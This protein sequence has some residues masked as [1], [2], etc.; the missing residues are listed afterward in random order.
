MLAIKVSNK[1]AGESEG[2]YHQSKAILAII[3]FLFLFEEL[4]AKDFR[5]WAGTVLT[6]RTLQELSFFDSRAQAKRNVLRAI[7]TVAKRLGNAKAVCRKCYIHHDVLN[8]YSLT[9][10]LSRSAGREF[11]SK[12]HEMPPEEAPVLALRCQRFQRD[13]RLVRG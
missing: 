3:P 11:R 8:T 10:M 7:E 1:K 12:L 4:T 6:A 5:T 13:R 9:D 2:M